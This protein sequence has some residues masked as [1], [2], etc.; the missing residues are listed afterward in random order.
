MLSN[1]PVWLFDAKKGEPPRWPTFGM[2][3]VEADPKVPVAHR[4]EA[5]EHG[6]VRG[7]VVD[8]IKALAST[9]MEAH[10][11]LYLEKATFVR[12]IPIPTL[13]VSTTE[14]DITPERVR[15][16]YES[17]RKAALR[18]PRPLGLR[19]LQG[20]VP[21]AAR[22]TPAAR[23]SLPARL[24]RDQRH[25]RAPSLALDAEHDPPAG[26]RRAPPRRSS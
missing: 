22:T 18:L 11:R 8:Y 5:T 7:S 16:L 12:T 9:M 26:R 20:R 3:L 15:A 25:L 23:S 21:L 6:V 19:G 13:G 2:L 4:V 14:F 10:D 24:S 1:F 17:G